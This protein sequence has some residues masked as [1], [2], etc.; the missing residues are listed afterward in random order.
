[1]QI[2]RSTFDNIP[3]IIEII[4]DAKEYLAS[5]QIDQWQNGYPNA[6]QIEQVGVSAYL[7]QT[8]TKPVYCMIDVLDYNKRTDGQVLNN[9]DFYAHPEKYEAN[10]MRFAKVTDYFIAG[11]FFGEG[12]PYLFH[13]I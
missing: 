7:T 11:H 5:S 3:A 9:S 8:F 12:S 2:K 1:M 6:M 4:N 10:F 13:V